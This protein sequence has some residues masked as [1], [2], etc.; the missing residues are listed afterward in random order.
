MTK[1]TLLEFTV[2][3]PTASVFRT[4]RACNHDDPRVTTLDDKAWTPVLADGPV[5]GMAVFDG[6][7]AGRVDREVGAAVCHMHDGLVDHWLSYAWGGG[8]AKVWIGDLG[9]AFADYDLLW[10]G[11][12]NGVSRPSRNVL[13]IQLKEPDLDQPVLYLGYAG[14]G[15]LEG[16]SGVKNQLKPWCFGACQFVRAQL[17]DPIKQIYQ[18]HGYGAVEGIDEVFEGGATLGA[19]ATSYTTAQLQTFLDTAPAQGAWS[20]LNG[21]GL[22]R[23]GSQPSFPISAHVRGDNVNGYV[24]K[25]GDIINRLYEVIKGTPLN[26]ATVT[27]LNAA[28]AQPVDLFLNEQETL[29]DVVSRLMLNVGGYAFLASDG[30]LRLGL[31]R[32]GTSIGDLDEQDKSQT[33]VRQLKE[34]VTSAPVYARRHGAEQCHYVHNASNVVADLA[35]VAADIEAAQQTADAKNTVWPPSATPPSGSVIEGDLWP[36]TSTT[37]HTMRRYNAAGSTWVATATQGADFNANVINIPTPIQ[38]GNLT[39][40]GYLDASWMEYTPPGGAPVN[41]NTLMPAEAGSDVTGNN[42]AATIANQGSG[43]TANT[44][45]ELDSSAWVHLSSVQPGATVGENLV[46]NGELLTDDLSGMALDI[47]VSLQTGG[48]GDPSNY[49]LRLAAN[50]NADNIYVGG[51]VDDNI[52]NMTGAIPCAE[53]DRIYYR[54]LARNNTNTSNA[55]FRFSPP[56]FI[57]PDDYDGVINGSYHQPGPNWEWHEGYIEIP[58][59]TNPIIAIKGRFDRITASQELDIAKIVLARVEPGADVT[60]NDPRLRS[61]DYGAGRNENLIRDPDFT[62]PDGPFLS[63]NPTIGLE[64]NTPYLSVPAGETVNF[65]TNSNNVNGATDQVRVEPGKTYRLSAELKTVGGTRRVRLRVRPRR[66][67]GSAGPVSYPYESGTNFDTAGAWQRVEVT[68]TVPD[69]ATY[70]YCEIGVDHVNSGTGTEAH[71]RFPRAST[72]AELATDGGT[73]ELNLFEND[74][75]PLATLANFRTNLGE[76][77][78]IANQGLLST[79]DD[80]DWD[81]HVLSRPAELTDGRIPAG[82]TPTGDMNR[83]MPLAIA[84]AS[85]LLRFNGG[86]LFTGETDA[87]RTALH[88]AATIANQGWGATAAEADASNEYTQRPLN[89]EA[90]GDWVV[91]GNRVKKGIASFGNHGG[92]HSAEKFRAVTISM[93][94]DL[95]DTHPALRGYVGIMQNKIAV[96]DNDADFDAELRFERNSDYIRLTVAGVTQVIHYPTSLTGIATLEYDGVYVRAIVNGEEIWSGE[97][98]HDMMVYVTYYS[99]YGGD[100]GQAVVSY[101]PS[102]YGNIKARDVSDGPALR[103][104][105]FVDKNEDKMT[106]DGPNITLDT[107]VGWAGRG[108]GPKFERGCFMQFSLPANGLRGQVGL[109]PDILPGDIP[110]NAYTDCARVYHIN[111]NNNYLRFYRGDNTSVNKVEAFTVADVISCFYDGTEIRWYKNNE[112]IMT[113]TTFGTDIPVVPAFIPLDVGFTAV[114]MRCGNYD[115]EIEAVVRGVRYD[116][117]LVPGLNEAQAFMLENGLAALDAYIRTAVG[118]AATFANQAAIATDHTAEV[119]ADVTANAVPT[120]E[121]TTTTIISADYQGTVIAG[122]LPK[123]IKFT[124]KRGDTDVSSSTTWSIHATSGCTATVSASGNVSI[125]A[126]TASGYVTVRSVRDGV[127][128]DKSIVVTKQNAPPPSTGGGSGTTVQD[129]SLIGVGSTAFSAVTS[130]MEVETGPNGQIAFSAP[131]TVTDSGSPAGTF[132]VELKWQYK[133]TTSSTWLDAASAVASNPD[134]VMVY[135]SEPGFNFYYPNPEGSVTS[136]P[137]KTGLTASTA[138]DVR[139]M[140]RRTTSSPANSVVLLGTASATGS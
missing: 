45:G 84:D 48:V 131:L 109:S 1:A 39:N 99:P 49:F 23:L 116:G 78:T 30:G 4:V 64:G 67:V 71:V 79:R 120:L 15:G 118:E 108:R 134:L 105:T 38:T 102:N 42:E 47:G 3:D 87:D 114:N 59:Q 97:T 8:T 56:K 5:V 52:T 33:F 27:A 124:R 75:G 94:F 19:A 117:T 130:E 81:S 51:G 89:F 2:Y 10:S 132:E 54:V 66:S 29:N 43:A 92:V 50:E 115:P 98:T 119:G 73:F 18:V 58:A 21:H 74:G 96:G 37:P 12:T 129:S 139:L 72:I 113:D 46:P 106:I 14:T 83:P 95:N 28:A 16:V 122:Q 55:N 35:E 93:P 90:V 36:D 126:C 133:L 44:L 63:G 65:I 11:E 26:A 70:D 62:D 53:G 82:L 41:V 104:W 17:I 22:F 127:T 24:T 125:T 68:F 103:S 77:A 91:E 128:L 123:V 86:A 34:E 31:V 137:T 121:G 136:N 61:V 69:D 7:F 20:R 76:A 112:L 88:E 40:D 13:E 60:A 100:N 138:Y 135:E 25:T 57:A 80:V 9:D 140:A 110:G 101:S 6:A 32:F 111:A 107:Y 85:D